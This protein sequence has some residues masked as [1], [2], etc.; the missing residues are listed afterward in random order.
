MKDK[1]VLVGPYNMWKLFAATDRRGGIVEEK[2]RRG[3]E[4]LEC[5]M[6][7]GT[8]GGVIDRCPGL[9]KMESIS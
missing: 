1:K 2:R 8:E 4:R 3:R 7:S 5:L 9:T 6:I